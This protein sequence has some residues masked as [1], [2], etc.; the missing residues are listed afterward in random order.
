VTVFSPGGTI[1]STGDVGATSGGVVPQL[2]AAELIHAARFVRKTHTASPATFRSRTAGPIGWV[3][4]G[5]PRI[6]LRPAA[7]DRDVLAAAADDCPAVALLSCTLGDD[8]R[9]VGQVERQRY[10]GLVIDVF[11][12]GH[13]PGH[14]VPMLAEVASRI[15]VVLASRTGGG[16][17]LHETYGFSGS[18]RDLL[19]CG[20]IPAGFLDGPQGADPAE[21]AARRAGGCR[22]RGR[23]LLTVPRLRA[24]VP[25][26]A[27]SLAAVGIGDVK[28]PAGVR[29]TPAVT[30]VR[31][32][33]AFGAA[34]GRA[35]GMIHHPSPFLEAA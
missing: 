33:W 32:H 23:R 12:G 20:L 31:E 25:R 18:E 6:G 21:P 17:V 2:G 13:V 4:E 3:V 27:A 26:R 22:R 24:L 7:L 30:A 8:L 16:E 1:A 35:L 9:L 28:A 14:V 19:A 34:P 29:H 10:A 5:C 15:P 11:G